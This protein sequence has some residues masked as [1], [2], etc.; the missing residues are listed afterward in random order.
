MILDER[1]RTSLKLSEFL[2]GYTKE[3]ELTCDLREQQSAAKAGY[4]PAGDVML[5]ETFKA[6][7]KG[8]S[9]EPS[10]KHPT[11]AERIA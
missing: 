4:S 11:L 7:R 10:E 5:L 2:P 9:E 6:L 1:R 3:E 8:E